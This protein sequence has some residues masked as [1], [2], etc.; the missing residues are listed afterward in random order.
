M[1]YIREK[2]IDRIRKREQGLCQR[3]I[4]GLQSINGVQLY[5]GI[6]AEEKAPIVS[7]N[8]GHHDSTFVSYELSK[9]AK[10]IA[11]AG[12]H[13]APHAHQT[14][15]TIVQGVIRFSPSHFTTDDEIN[16]ALEAVERIAQEEG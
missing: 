1:R 15:G 10:V 6:K 4:D 14:L 7:F 11:R 2:G 16:K 9:Q 12:L 13:C 3:L 5:G 8:I